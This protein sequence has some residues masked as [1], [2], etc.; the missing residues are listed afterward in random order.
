LAKHSC[1][2][3]NPNAVFIASALELE[4]TREV[5]WLLDDAGQIPEIPTTP[6]EFD[7]IKR[8]K[9]ANT[10]FSAGLLAVTEHVWDPEVGCLHKQFLFVGVIPLSLS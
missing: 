1:Q 3:K 6:R 7:R 9:P 5:Q 10:G 4:A 8:K 2:G